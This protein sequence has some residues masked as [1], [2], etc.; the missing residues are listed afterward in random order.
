ME[1]PDDLREF[2]AIPANRTILLPGCEVRELT[3]YAPEELTERVFKVSTADFAINERWPGWDRTKNRKYEFRGVDLVKE[4]RNYSPKGVFIW[5]PALGVYGQWDCD[6]LKIMVFPG[7]K[8]SDIAKAPKRYFNAQ[9][10]PDEVFHRYL[11]PWEDETE[12]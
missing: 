7:V 4:C 3:L 9:W 6:H 11:R 8:W 12:A 1:I 2:L 5:F 10:E